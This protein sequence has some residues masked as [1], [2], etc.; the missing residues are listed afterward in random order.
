MTPFWLHH[1]LQPDCRPTP[2]V[3]PS[4]K[5]PESSA[6]EENNHNDFE[7]Y[8]DDNDDNDGDVVDTQSGTFRDCGTFCERFQRKI[9]GYHDFLNGLKYQLQFEDERML[10]VVE[11][12]GAGFW[13]LAQNCLSRERRM[14]TSRG[15]SPVTWERET[16]NAMFYR[17]RPRRCDRDS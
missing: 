4:P 2:P 10:E 7:G 14:N 6:A 3:S 9:N 11:R 12:E 17:S 5:G 15:S 16:S 1:V 13:R 8:D